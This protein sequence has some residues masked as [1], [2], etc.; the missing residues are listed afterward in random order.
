MTI[1][2]GYLLL[3]L[4]LAL[5]PGKILRGDECR[6]FNCEQLVRRM[7]DKTRKRRRW[8]KLPAVWIDPVR[9]F[10]AAWLLKDALVRNPG[11]HGLEAQLPTLLPMLILTV[12]LTVQTSGNREKSQLV[13]PAGYLAGLMIGWLPWMISVPAVIL[14][15]SSAVAFRRWEAAFAIG[16][17]TTLIIGYFFMGKSIPLIWAAGVFAWPMFLA[18][19]TGSKLVLPVR[20]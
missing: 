20:A 12:G 5:F 15:G 3:G 2:W 6:H 13:A 7:T 19:L 11:A 8:W 18:W 9:G 14:G 4:I 16:S 1:S 17:A 10:F